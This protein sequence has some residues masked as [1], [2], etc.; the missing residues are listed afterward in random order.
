MALVENVGFLIE[1]S[2]KAYKFSSKVDCLS[3]LLSFDSFLSIFLL[4]LEMALLSS[5][6]LSSLSIDFSFNL[7]YLA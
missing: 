3:V 6:S 4:P 1:F 2:P 5:L 7:L